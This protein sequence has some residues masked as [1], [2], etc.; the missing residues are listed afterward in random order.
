MQDSVANCAIY[1]QEAG[2]ILSITCI[3]PLHG[4]TITKKT[5]GKHTD[6]TTSTQQHDHA[7][8]LNRQDYKTLSLA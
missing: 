8:P 2:S 1:T 5:D 7:R 3:C 4:V 6:M